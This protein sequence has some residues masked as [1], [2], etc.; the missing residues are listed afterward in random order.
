VCGVPILVSDLSLELYHQINGTHRYNKQRTSKKTGAIRFSYHCAQN[1]DRQHKP[2]KHDDAEKHCT[3][4]QMEC[5]DCGS[6]LHITVSDESTEALVHFKHELDHIPYC[7]IDVPSAVKEFI[8]ANPNLNTSQVSKM[9]TYK[10]AIRNTN[11]CCD[12]DLESC[13][14]TPTVSRPHQNSLLAACDLHPLG[15]N[16]S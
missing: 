2:K 16:G 3:S 5:F 12:V 11:R 8:G 9:I 4:R 15:K 6:W 14:D 7:S 10:F 13:L 1:A